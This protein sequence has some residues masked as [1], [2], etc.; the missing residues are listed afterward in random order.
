M[1]TVPS[2]PSCNDNNN[3]N[4]NNNSS[5]S[6]NNNNNNN[7]NNRSAAIARYN[8]IKSL[9]FFKPSLD[10]GIAAAAAAA[11]GSAAR[12]SLITPA[13]VDV[14]RLNAASPIGGDGGLCWSVMV[15]S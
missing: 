14:M 12:T 10:Q 7:N 3:N 6:N 15:E 13:Q 2:R 8:S 9:S 4:N 11:P 5:S 1:L